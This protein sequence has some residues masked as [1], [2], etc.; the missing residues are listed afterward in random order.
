VF[1]VVSETKN[2]TQAAQ[3]LNISQS[4][5]SYHIK[6][7]ET[8]LSIKLFKRTASGLDL[9]ADGALLAEHVSTGLR[10]IETGLEKISNR[11]GSVRVALLLS[12][13]NHNNT[14]AK[15][16]NADNFADLG[17]QWGRGNWKNFNVT[18]L[19]PEKMVVVCSPE[20][21]K[22][23]SIKSA[24]DIRNCTLLHVDDERMWAEWFS[25]NDVKPDA[26][27]SQMMLQDRHFQLSST[28]NGLGVSLFASWLVEQEL[29]N[30]ELINP[31]NTE[32]ETSFAYHLIAPKKALMSQSAKQFND[33][34][35]N[36]KMDHA[37]NRNS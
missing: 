16:D 5:V 14:Y 12:I 10:Y 33:W 37:G 2:V 27:Q 36:T 6:K 25:K 30:G 32:F 28:I 7:L 29:Q 31:F 18:K 15:M 24:E 11:V 9:T 23:H 1:N 35:V 13:L 26:A 17:I 3:L 22:Q 21:L 8:D 4:S 20:Y 34:I 19:W